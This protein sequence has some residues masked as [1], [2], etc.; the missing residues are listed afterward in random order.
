[1]HDHFTENSRFVKNR[2]IL[3]Q[4]ANNQSPIALS[5]SFYFR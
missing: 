4:Q 2:E 5:L 1:M 3:M